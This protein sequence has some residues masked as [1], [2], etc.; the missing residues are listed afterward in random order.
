[1]SK[2][3]PSLTDLSSHSFH[4]K[5][6]RASVEQD[7]Q[8]QLSQ[9]SL[10]LLQAFL[11]KDQGQ[12]TSD[13]GPIQAVQ[14][15]FNFIHK[16]ET[17]GRAFRSLSNEEQA[18]LKQ[19][20]GE[21]RLQEILSI[22]E[23]RNSEEYWASALNFGVRLK[24]NHQ[25]A[26]AGGVLEWIGQSAG[27]ENIRLRAQAELDAILGKGNAGLRA[28]FLVSRFSHDVTDHRMIVPM[29]A[30]SAAFSLVRTATLARLAGA[31]ARTW[32]QTGLGARA[33]SGLAGFAVEVPVFSMSSRGLMQLGGEAIS[34][35]STSV[36]KDLAGATLTLGTL[37]LLGFAGNQ[38]FL[39]IHGFNELGV[40]TRLNGL[41]KFNQVFIPQG[42]MFLG[43]LA[44]HKLE[45]KIGLRP[46]VD[47]ATTVMDTLASQLSLGIGSHLGHQMLGAKFASFQKELGVRA[48]VFTKFGDPSP[49]PAGAPPHLTRTGGVR[50]GPPARGEGNAG[51]PSKIFTNPF[52]TPMWAMMGAGGLGGGAGEGGGK[53]LPGPFGRL[54]PIE[55]NKNNPT[56][57]TPR[58]ALPQSDVIPSSRAR[59]S[60]KIITDLHGTSLEFDIVSEN[61]LQE[62]GHRVQALVES[63]KDLIHLGEEDGLHVK[64]EVASKLR[65][66][67]HLRHLVQGLEKRIAILLDV[68]G[69]RILRLQATDGKGFKLELQDAELQRHVE[70]ASTPPPREEIRPPSPERS[71]RPA[72]PAIPKVAEKAAA[73]PAPSE[74][75]GLPSRLEKLTQALGGNFPPDLRR[76][77]HWLVKNLQKIQVRGASFEQAVEVISLAESGLALPEPSLDAAWD[78]YAEFSGRKP[79]RQPAEKPKAPE[80]KPEREM[81]W[82]AV[83]QRISAIRNRAAIELSGVT[84]ASATMQLRKLKAQ[85]WGLSPEEAHRLLDAFET[86][87]NQKDDRTFKT[88]REEFEAQQKPGVSPPVGTGSKSA[89]DSPSPDSKT[90]SKLKAD[91]GHL[92]KPTETPA[93]SPTG[94][95]PAS[96]PKEIHRELEALTAASKAEWQPAL[97]LGLNLHR[98]LTRK[99]SAGQ[100]SDFQLAAR[101]LADILAMR[102][103]GSEP[104]QV[105]GLLGAL[106]AALDG[107]IPQQRVAEMRQAMLPKI[108][109][110]G[111]KVVS[112]S[113]QSDASAGDGRREGNDRQVPV[114]PVPP[115]AGG[116]SN[117]NR[118]KALEFLAQKKSEWQP[119]YYLAR[120]LYEQINLSREAD[121]ESVE[122]AK[123]YLCDSIQDWLDAVQADK[124]GHPAVANRSLRALEKVFKG[125][126][127]WE[128]LEA[129]NPKI[130]S[131]PPP[132]KPKRVY[133]PRPELSD[134]QSD[135]WDV[136]YLTEGEL[137]GA[138]IIRSLAAGGKGEHHPR[139]IYDALEVMEKKGL[140]LSRT[141]PNPRSSRMPDL[142]YVWIIPEVRRKFAL[143]PFQH[144][145]YNVLVASGAEMNVTAVASALEAAGAKGGKPASTGNALQEMEKKGFVQSRTEPNPLKGL[146][147]LRI[148]RLPGTTPVE[149]A[150][151][152]SVPLGSEKQAPD[153]TASETSAPEGAEAEP[154]MRTY[155][156]RPEFTEVQSLIWDVL[157]TAHQEMQGNEIIQEARRKAKTDFVTW[158]YYSNLSKMEAK[159]WLESRSESRTGGM[160]PLKYFRIPEAVRQEQVLSPLQKIIYRAMRRHGGEMGVGEV[161]QMLRGITEWTGSFDALRGSLRKMRDRGVLE[162][163]TV[164][165]PHTGLGPVPLYRVK[166][167][168]IPEVKLVDDTAKAEAQPPKPSPPAEPPKGPTWDQVGARAKKILAEKIEGRFEDGGLIRIRA[169]LDAILKRHKDLPPAQADFALDI[170]EAAI[171]N[172]NGFATAAT[173]VDQMLLH[174]HALSTLRRLSE[175][176]GEWDEVAAEAN[177]IFNAFFHPHGI[178]NSRLEAGIQ[179]LSTIL[180]E[181]SKSSPEAIL[182]SLRSDY[183]QEAIDT[184]SSRPK[185]SDPYDTHGRDPFAGK[186]HPAPAG[187]VTEWE[188]DV[189]PIMDRASELLQ[190][191]ALARANQIFAASDEVLAAIYYS[192]HLDTL[193]TDLI[194]Y[195]WASETVTLIQT[196]I[197]KGPE[198]FNQLAQELRGLKVKI[199]KQIGREM[200]SQPEPDPVK[201][202]ESQPASAPQREFQRKSWEWFMERI[203]G[204]QGGGSGEKESKPSR[205][206]AVTPPEPAEN[207]APAPGLD[208]RLEAVEEKPEPLPRPSPPPAKD[209]QEVVLTPKVGER[210]GLLGLG[211]TVRFISIPSGSEEGER[212]FRAHLLLPDLSEIIFFLKTDSTGIITVNNDGK[213]SYRHHGETAARIIRAANIAGF[214]GRV[215][216][217]LEDGQTPLDLDISRSVVSGLPRLD[218]PENQP[219]YGGILKNLFSPYPPKRSPVGVIHHEMYSDNLKL[220]GQGA[221]FQKFLFHLSNGDRLEVEMKV[222][223]H[224]GRKSEIQYARLHRFGS[225]ER[226]Y[227]DLDF[228]LIGDSKKSRMILKGKGYDVEISFVPPTQT[229]GEPEFDQFQ[230]LEAPRPIHLRLFEPEQAHTQG[231][232]PRRP[233]SIPPAPAEI[234]VEPIEHAATRVMEGN[235][236]ALPELGE[237]AKTRDEALQQLVTIYDLAAYPE[238]DADAFGGVPPSTL[239][240]MVLLT[241]GQAARQN[242]KG[243]MYITALD[244]DGIREAAPEI[245]QLAKEE[246]PQSQAAWSYLQSHKR[247]P[248]IFRQIVTLAEEGFI[249]AKTLVF[250]MKGFESFSQAL[251]M[252]PADRDSLESLAMAREFNG[253][254]NKALRNYIDQF[255]PGRAPGV[256]EEL[257]Q[258]AFSDSK[259]SFIAREKISLLAVQ[260]KNVLLGLI[261]LYIGTQQHALKVGLQKML[262]EIKPNGL[263]DYRKDTAILEALAEKFQNSHAKKLLEENLAL[264]TPVAPSVEMKPRYLQKTTP[265]PVPPSPDAFATPAL[266]KAKRII[267]DHRVGKTKKIMKYGFYDELHPV[268]CREMTL[269]EMDALAVSIL[270]ELTRAVEMR[271]KPRKFVLLTDVLNLIYA[272]TDHQGRVKISQGLLKLKG[273]SPNLILGHLTSPDEPA[274]SHHGLIRRVRQQPLE[275]EISPEERQVLNSVLGTSQNGDSAVVAMVK[276]LVHLAGKT[277]KMDQRDGYYL[278]LNEAVQDLAPEEVLRLGEQYTAELV[279]LGPWLTETP[280]GKDPI[281]NEALRKFTVGINALRRLKELLPPK[282]KVRLDGMLQRERSLQN[283]YLTGVGHVSAVREP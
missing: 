150:A 199:W 171:D 158:T 125:E 210:T 3:Q 57:K 13:Q 191:P 225:E 201:P 249:Q 123:H 193:V 276:D 44:A 232:V 255:T 91:P 22:S 245:A 132:A 279:R 222:E 142:R 111:S 75:A 278:R 88:I 223:H 192:K 70:T 103:H 247:E 161:E 156:H 53:G 55:G 179:A 140:I 84:M 98:R 159:G 69:Q 112:V 127:S 257:G 120:A 168:P 6:L 188:R 45:E 43:M 135:V 254:A 38:G 196:A 109:E 243:L 59:H 118:L 48:D 25:L 246:G 146:P 238:A 119:I 80:P 67:G 221:H 5:A 81:T 154:S 12:G 93:A 9:H 174:K 181:V 99:D 51:R 77:G 175:R 68:D 263:A 4:S 49:A 184:A 187:P 90:T 133:I 36:G 40:V 39:K 138:D 149:T 14:K 251:E 71:V 283:V 256:L 83:E 233:T 190:E 252:N 166:A 56:T 96:Y 212:N 145:I 153:R 173:V 274:G 208:L 74:W 167:L 164:P 122:R 30:G 86:A 20:V 8:Q 236:D 107:K 216:L 143:S 271:A 131:R 33:V 172:S 169:T 94:D 176:G 82:E 147:P 137:R 228:N 183:V 106:E 260:Y 41:A 242:P 209:L 275:E 92:S 186:E 23:C 16:G 268:I 241:I 213:A 270:S 66:E 24:Q 211:S 160:P 259:A 79:H 231:V 10:N 21:Q 170:F 189:V 134:L 261:D 18:S 54:S 202:Q 76:S 85:K 272:H 2:L 194:R 100:I 237:L 177:R 230:V 61:S 73:E 34:W 139:S 182:K 50:W 101:N 267:D 244:G 277:I 114:S 105:A 195:E 58:R 165:G 217:G 197:D 157:F 102:R 200:Q 97:D 281:S 227:V 52:L 42:S 240:N 129:F 78:K 229:K 144:E 95:L 214:R 104:D 124:G 163:R 282:E 130:S 63:I 215:R 205:S 60:E 35:D 31:S 266:R 207:L 126:M 29:I 219:K 273:K 220:W 37:K 1:M 113:L 280:L 128:E 121:L 180:F 28:E 47:G 248:R 239:K 265:S 185:S 62:Q 17:L 72:T 250:E 203:T 15:L 117:L 46:H 11:A 136:L 110:G 7:L 234:D 162:S 218:L 258:I 224:A 152:P 89:G 269:E 116:D 226:D 27:S 178:K 253:R 32:Y 148:Y 141:E 264:S 155:I 262:G 206:E 64:G 19:K 65:H 151:S 204:P 87:L 108:S 198:H 115:T 26:E 235:L